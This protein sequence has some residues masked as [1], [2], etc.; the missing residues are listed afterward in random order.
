MAADEF[1]P[2][3][4]AAAGGVPSGPL[5]LKAPQ[6][7]LE[8]ALDRMNPVLARMYLG[9]LFVLA[10]EANP[11]RIALSA[12]GF[13]EL[14]EKLPAHMDVGMP[15]HAGSLTSEAK[16]ARIAW[17]RASNQSSCR[18]P[19]GTWS[20]AIDAPL[21]KAI[22]A[23]EALFTWLDANKPRRRDE[24]DLALTRLDPGGRGLPAPLQSLNIAHWETMQDFF[25]P[26]SHHKRRSPVEE[27]EK[28]VEALERFLLERLV[29]RTFDDHD[30]I[31]EILK[32]ASGGQGNG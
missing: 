13:R 2:G 1:K 4:L 7:A 32:E 8:K 15:A 18:K 10:D 9:A 29:P 23:M 12:H 30:A 20:G 11:D 6:L 17:G 28:W 26:H 5:L 14:M 27:F 31:D 22:K 3:M 24:I 21:R 25:V 19:D 16:N